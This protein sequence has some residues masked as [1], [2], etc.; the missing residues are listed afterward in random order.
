MTEI[1]KL[2]LLLVFFPVGQI[3][4][5][6]IPDKNT[7]LKDPSD[8]GEFMWWIGCWFYMACWVEIPDRS[9]LWSVTP[10]VMHR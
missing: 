2:E 8:L 10:P 7:V 9:D 6:F 3:N 4:T 1:R 5:I